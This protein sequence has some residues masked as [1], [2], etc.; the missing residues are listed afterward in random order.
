MDKSK[1]YHFSVCPNEFSYSREICMY[2]KEINI[3]EL[4]TTD[5]VSIEV[6]EYVFTLR[7]HIL[8]DRL[9]ILVPVKPTGIMRLRVAVN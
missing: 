8:N 1:I 9:I 7:H 6:T 3:P 4:E 5:S 2:M